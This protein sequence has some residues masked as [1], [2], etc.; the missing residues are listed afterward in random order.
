MSVLARYWHLWLLSGIISQLVWMLFCEGCHGMLV[1]SGTVLLC[2]S[3][4]VH[5]SFY[6]ILIH[7]KKIWFLGKRVLL[8]MFSGR[9]SLVGKERISVLKLCRNRF[10]FFLIIEYDSVVTGRLEGKAFWSK[11]DVLLCSSGLEPKQ[12]S[13]DTFSCALSNLFWNCEV[14]LNKSP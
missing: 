2:W 13:W 1:C 7:L 11:P 5:I 4:T 12:Q 9:I 14:F 6:P 3:I 10:F 8:S